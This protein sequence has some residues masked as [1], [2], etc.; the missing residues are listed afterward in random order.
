MIILLLASTCYFFIASICALIF[1]YK[2]K[3]TKAQINSYAPF[4]SCLKPV[5]GADEKTEENLST[6]LNQN[7]SK[8]EVVVGSAKE[9]DDGLR[10]AQNLATTHSLLLCVHGEQGLGSN[11]KVRNLC[12]I[13]NY[14]SPESKIWVI[15]DAD[16][17][18]DSQ[19]LANIVALFQN[20]QVGAV[21]CLYR[22]NKTYDLGGLCEA[23]Y[24]EQSFAPGVIL[25]STFAPANY[26]F[27]AT[28]AVRKQDFEKVGSFASLE[29]YLADDNLI[30]KRIA[31]NGKKVILSHYIVE[32]VLGKQYLRNTF[33]HLLRWNKTIRICQ[34]IGYFFSGI[35]YFFPWFALYAITSLY[36]NNP[37][38]LKILLLCL[39]IRIICAIS[40]ALALGTSF[41]IKRA[42]LAP[43]WDMFSFILWL[44]SFV[45]KTI[46]WH[47]DTF[48]LKKDGTMSKISK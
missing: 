21:S 48:I 15:S 6:F 25:A 33:L 23:L 2:R 12:N 3:H 45:G 9:D 27:G 36:A 46:T 47:D 16:I 13:Q 17:R 43:I 8:Y 35:T 34:P 18:V 7:Y 4:V 10:I 1:Y 24:I 40:V 5:C 11:L 38:T 26:A 39:I 14:A 28:I 29:N 37:N 30:G 42:M 44:L 32:D 20:E 22:V 31:E 41:G 19:Y